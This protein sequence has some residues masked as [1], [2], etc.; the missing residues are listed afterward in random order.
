MPERH[1]KALK[2]AFQ[3]L[4]HPYRLLILNV[5][6]GGL[7][8]QGDTGPIRDWDSSPAKAGFGFS[9]VS[10]VAFW[11]L[12]RPQAPPASPQ[13]V[14]ELE[15]ALRSYKSSSWKPQ[16]LPKGSTETSVQAW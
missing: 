10:A 12:G 16:S 8:A 11:A 9:A 4:L 3:K 7:T 14:G 5:A 2:S 13:G 6:R 15:M 1:L